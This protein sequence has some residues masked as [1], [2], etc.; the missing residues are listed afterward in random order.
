MDDKIK[1][2]LIAAL[3]VAGGRCGDVST[4]D[5]VFATTSVENMID[6]E[7]AFCE[8]FDTKSDDVI[9]SEIL[10]KIRAL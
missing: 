9:A 6:L 2:V 7:T 4:E 10:P 3:N 8:A 5:G 1:E